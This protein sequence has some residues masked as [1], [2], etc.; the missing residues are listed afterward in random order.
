MYSGIYGF[1]YYVARLAQS[2]EHET[3]NL[4]VVGSS[5]TLGAKY[6][7]PVFQISKLPFLEFRAFLCDQG[8]GSLHRTMNI[9]RPKESFTW[10]KLPQFW[11]LFV[12]GAPIFARFLQQPLCL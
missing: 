8:C 11:S 10:N 3:L 12:T 9:G 6:F 4:R 5:P 2:V 1:S 7:C